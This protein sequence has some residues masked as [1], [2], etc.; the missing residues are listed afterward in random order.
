MVLQTLRQTAKRSP[1]NARAVEVSVIIP[2]LNEADTIGTCVAKARRALADEGIAGEVVVADNGS[3]DGSPRIAALMGARV[4]HVPQRGYGS[5]LQQGIASS[6]GEFIVMGDADDS[7]DFGDVPRFVASLREGN[8]L[9]QGCR[10]PAGGGRVLPGAMPFT[11]RFI[12]NPL[13]TSLARLMFRVPVRDIYC[14]MRGFTRDMYDRL[15]LHC[16]GMEFATEMIIKASAHHE[17]IAE[18]PITLYPDG[19]NGRPS[20]LRTF[21]DGW[22]TLRLFLLYSPRWL[23]IIPGLLLVLLGVIGYALALPGVQIAGARLDVHTLLV[24]SLTLI[25]G[26]QSILFGIFSKTFVIHEGLLPEDR[27]LTRLF[28]SFG[29]EWGLAIGTTAFL[30]GIGLLSAVLLQWSIVEFGPLDYPITM[31]YVIPGVTI[32]AVGF[33]TILASFVMSILGLGQR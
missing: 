18:L 2:C 20:H 25:L 10:L 28:E 1:T 24:S 13:L 15:D 27:R 11:H 33:Q 26:Y 19:R 6:R 9:V 8:E 16:T 17:R 23:F 7:Y 4:V 31:R 22:R 29:L 12:G 3:T 30:A 5:A 21:R 32:C 14:G